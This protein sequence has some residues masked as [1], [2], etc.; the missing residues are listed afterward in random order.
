MTTGHLHVAYDAVPVDEVSG[1]FPLS[2]LPP[3][4]VAR[5]TDAVQLIEA[6]ADEA[7]LAVAPVSMATGYQFA[8]APVT[9]VQLDRLPT[10]ESLLDRTSL[11]RSAASY[12]LL[13]FGHVPS[14]QNHSIR[15]WA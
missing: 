8:Q 13:V 10:R 2:S 11:D 12:D 3:R 15:E 9:A 7:I 5:D 1:L 6:T 14:R 4:A